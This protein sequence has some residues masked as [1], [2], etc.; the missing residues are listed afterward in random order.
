MEMPAVF[1]VVERIV[2]GGDGCPGD[3]G[4][5]EVKLS[6]SAAGALVSASKR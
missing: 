5:P 3:S 4:D 2:L 6:S 1:M